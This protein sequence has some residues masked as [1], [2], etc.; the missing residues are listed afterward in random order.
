MTIKNALISAFFIF[1]AFAVLNPNPFGNNPDIIADESY[2]LTS[3]LSA[4][5]KHTLPG[6][7]FSV[8]GSYY[9]GPQTYV[10]TLV[11]I[12]ALAVVA[13]FS[14]FSPLATKMWVAQNTGELLH[15]LRLVNGAVALGT[16]VFFFFYFKKRKIP[17]PLVITLTLFLFLLLGNVLLIQ[18]LHTAKVWVFYVVIVA[19]MSAVFIAQEYYLSRF[20]EPFL[21]KKTYLVLLIWS[22]VL[23]FF[24]VNVA[25]VSM[26]LLLFYAI[27]LE[28]ITVRD[29]WEYVLKYWYLFVLATLT[30][31]S[32]LYRLFIHEGISVFKTISVQTNDGG[33]DWFSRLYDPLLYTVESHPL[34]VILYVVG[35]GTVIFFILQQ[36]TPFRYLRSHRYVAIALFHPFLVY[37]LF[38]AVMGFSIAP[39]YVIMLTIALAFSATLLISDRRE[40]F[41][42]RLALPV[43]IL[44]GILFLG[45]GTHAISLYWRPSSEKMLLATITEKYNSPNSIFVM[46]PSALRLV[47]PIN[48]SSL[49]LQSERQKNMERFKFLSEHREVVRDNI[50]FKP[51]ILTAYNED[52]ER[53]A[54]ARVSG[55]SFASSTVWSI[56]TRCETLCT[57]Q[58]TKEKTCFVIPADTECKYGRNEPNELKPFLSFRQLGNTYIVRKVR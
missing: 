31:I 27:L 43:T 17:K 54:F 33:I 9:G 48:E 14:G 39:R 15:L 2:F 30:Q 11:L 13:V 56:S 4:I 42:E 32:F 38:H 41:G 53:E 51:I 3:S 25:A 29:V 47:L 46:E 58:E 23:V 44:S 50:A 37:F 1:L 57:S 19:S 21:S 5:I 45:I 12:P 40:G 35:V 55:L 24:Q 6:W 8:S 49:S 18:L 28:H 34:A 20:H 52:E 7:E 16:L 26:L 36:K 22:A 10:D